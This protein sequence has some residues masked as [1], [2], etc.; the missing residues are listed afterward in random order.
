MTGIWLAAI[1]TILNLFSGLSVAQ[2]ATAQKFEGTDGQPIR[3][4][5][6]G[7]GTSIHP[8][9]TSVKQ[10]EVSKMSNEPVDFKRRLM[11]SLKS[12]SSMPAAEVEVKGNFREGYSYHIWFY[13][14]ADRTYRYPLII[15]RKG[16]TQEGDSYLIGKLPEHAKPGGYDVY[17]TGGDTRRE[18][19]TFGNSEK[20]NTLMFTVNQRSLDSYDFVMEFIG[21]E[22]FEESADGPGSD[23]IYMA[24]MG[25]NG[26]EIVAASRIYEGVDTNHRRD[27][28]VPLGRFRRNSE[29]I[30]V[31][32]L[33]EFDSDQSMKNSHSGPGAWPLSQAQAGWSNIVGVYPMKPMPI[34]QAN[35]KT[36]AERVAFYKVALASG[37]SSFSDDC[38]GVEELTFTDDELRTAILRNGKPV[39]KSLHYRGDTSHYRAI[40][41]IRMVK[42]DMN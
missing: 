11:I 19:P 25:L 33:G 31:V 7:T 22:C 37:I 29:A 18:S 4:A 39:E 13:Y 30:L 23:E 21:F 32:G 2:Q 15:T 35:L 20:S 38:L 16:K 12:K 1:I 5:R 26:N 3:P 42:P 6:P 8:A 10:S 27:E 36:R 17:V 14:Q 9:Y 28:I 24:A 41:T 34:T 40:F